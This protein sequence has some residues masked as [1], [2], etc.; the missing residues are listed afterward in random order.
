LT[1]RP[2][3]SRS[4]E[5]DYS[6]LYPTLSAADSNV[7]RQFGAGSASLEKAANS[8]YK[9]N[10]PKIWHV[11]KFIARWPGGSQ[12]G[13]WWEIKGPMT[14]IQAAIQ[15]QTFYLYFFVKN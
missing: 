4:S 9:A 1:Q 7:L 8:K 10:T 11:E 6:A 13:K 15:N 3:D 2:K 5:H 14:L 12:N